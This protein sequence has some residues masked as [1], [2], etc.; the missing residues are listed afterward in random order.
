[1]S[2]PNCK[3][4]QVEVIYLCECD[5]SLLCEYCLEE[6]TGLEHKKLTLEDVTANYGSYVNKKL[7][8]VD[9]RLITGIGQEVSS[10][11]CSSPIRT[12]LEDRVTAQ[13]TRLGRADS[14]RNIN[15]RQSRLVA[16]HQVHW[17]SLVR[18]TS[19]VLNFCLLS[20]CDASSKPR[21]NP[22]RGRCHE[23]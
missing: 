7:L 8:E 16:Q 21:P 3:I 18:E 15:S 22:N 5:S 9:E 1:M 14:R 12:A 6:H 19:L 10:Q 23:H 13:F 17:R 2:V 20:K 4:H 11:R